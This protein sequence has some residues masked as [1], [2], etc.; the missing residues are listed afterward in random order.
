EMSY[1][2]KRLQADIAYR[3]ML[4]PRINTVC[5]AIPPQQRTVYYQRR[6]PKRTRRLHG[7]FT[8]STTTPKESW[9]DYSPIYQLIESSTTP[10]S[11]HQNR[12]NYHQPAHEYRL[13]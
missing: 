6:F 10:P 8:L 1:E 7:P 12:W 2:N 11:T 5:S 4:D 13:R 3:K 9:K